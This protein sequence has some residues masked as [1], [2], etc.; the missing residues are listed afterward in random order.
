MIRI[1]SSL[2][3]LLISLLTSLLFGQEAPPPKI[4]ISGNVLSEKNEIVQNVIISLLDANTKNVIKTE[5]ISENVG[6]TFA[7]GN[8]DSNGNG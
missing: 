6:F 1:I 7:N 2:I 5:L 4:S 8:V 3:V